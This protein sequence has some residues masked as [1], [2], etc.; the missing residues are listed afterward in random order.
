MTIR[1]WFLLAKHILSRNHFHFKLF[2]A[3]E[4]DTIPMLFSAINHNSFSYLPFG[5]VQSPRWGRRAGLL[6]RR[7]PRFVFQIMKFGFVIFFNLA[8]TGKK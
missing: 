4:E 7:G 1:L 8:P 2:S 5:P 6:K 3:P